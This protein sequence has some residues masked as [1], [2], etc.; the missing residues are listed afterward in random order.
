MCCLTFG[1]PQPVP[2]RSVTYSHQTRWHMPGQLQR[3]ECRVKIEQMI[4]RLHA[5]YLS[6]LFTFQP[7]LICEEMFAWLRDSDR[8]IAGADVIG[9]SDFQQ[10]LGRII[11][12]NDLALKA[13]QYCCRASCGISTPSRHCPILGGV[14]LSMAH[15]HTCMRHIIHVSGG[16]ARRDPRQHQNQHLNCRMTTTK[17]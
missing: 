1:A 16:S 17:Q 11:W 13:E 2:T 12:C 4:D 3:A 14:Q 10:A 15:T 5:S 6:L 7:H 9:T 8:M